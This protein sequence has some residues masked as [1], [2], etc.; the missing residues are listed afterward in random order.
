MPTSSK[1]QRA[2]GRFIRRA[3]HHP[4]RAPFGGSLELRRIVLPRRIVCGRT[5]A[6]ISTNGGACRKI[7]RGGASAAHGRMPLIFISL[8]LPTYLVAPGGRFFEPHHVQ[9]RSVPRG[10]P[11]S[12]NPAYPCRLSTHHH[13]AALF[14]AIFILLQS[15]WPRAVYAIVI[16]RPIFGGRATR[17]RPAALF[18]RALGRKHD[19]FDHLQR[20]VGDRVVVIGCVAAGLYVQRRR[21]LLKTTR[22]VLGPA[23][24]LRQKAVARSGSSVNPKGILA[25]STNSHVQSQYR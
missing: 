9:A 3:I 24:K 21:R 1:R 23:Q 20:K 7:D 14:R 17:L 15:L 18:P 22:Q 12:R 25:L 6:I 11:R 2:I 5:H 16:G 19:I 8:L 4:G 10:G 13:P